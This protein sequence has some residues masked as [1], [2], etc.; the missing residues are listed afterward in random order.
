MG[1]LSPFFGMSGGHMTA[2]SS[3]SNLTALWA[4]RDCAGVQEVVA[5]EAAHLSVAKA[6]RILGLRHRT[7]PVDE[8]G[9]LDASSMPKDLR[10]SALVLTAGT[11]AAGAIDPLALT[12]RAAW[13]HVNAARAGPL[14]LTLHRER[15]TG[16]ELADSVAVSA[17][18]WLF[19]PK[20]SGLVFFRDVARADAAISF[21]GAYLA[22]PNVGLFGSHGATA[23]PLLATLLAWGRSGIAARVEHC[24]KMADELADFVKSD[25]RLRLFANPQAGII[26]WRPHDAARFDG[27][28]ER[29]PPGAV[30]TVTIAGERWFRM[31]AANPL[32]D[33][34]TITE[35]LRQSVA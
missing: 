11:T 14:R 4:A 7:V 31:V 33:V 10:K 17:H 35:R 19:Q 16:I 8:S 21:G 9:A 24:V 3:L 2:G 25:S 1:W 26:G 5:S 20:E 30:S 13:T 27:I 29:L 22:A 28:H 23:V 18:K 34:K 6:A 12:G 32:A 15:L